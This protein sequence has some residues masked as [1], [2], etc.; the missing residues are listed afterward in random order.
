[1]RG[2]FSRLTF[3]PD[4][5][6]TAVLFQQGRVQLDADA[7]EEAAIQLA[8][9]RTMAADVIGQHGGPAD[10]FEVT[11]VPRTE[12]GDPATLRIQRGRYYVDGVLADST[13]PA[14]ERPVTGE[15]PPPAGDLTYWDQ[16]FAYLDPELESDALPGTFPFLVYLRVHE[17]L[18]TAV[19]DPGIRESALGPALPDTAVRTRVVWQ[20]RAVDLGR[21]EDPSSAFQAWVERSR[22]HAFLAARTERPARVEDDPCIVAPDAA[23]R[24]EENQLYRVEIHQGGDAGTATFKWSR[25]NGSVTFPIE[26]I[27][28][29][30]VTLG[31][32]GRD[33]RLGLHVGDWTEVSDDASA[34]RGETGPLLR[35]EEIDVVGR[36]VRLSDEPAAGVGRIAS[37]HPL[38]RRWDQRRQTKRGAPELRDGAVRVVEGA[39]LDLEDGVQVWFDGKGTYR[40]GDYWLIPA[41]TLE[42]DVEWPR[43]AAGEPLLEP[44]AGVDV[45]YAPL[46]WVTGA[47]SEDTQ[48]LRH[49]FRPLTG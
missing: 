4:R 17:Q 8:L 7:N 32:L 46:A 49:Q 20:V 34:A 45:H 27:G 5:H 33:D 23:F 13:A 10:G 30:W 35:V 28:G 21:T 36:R 38:L 14:P 18:V 19:E 6:F 15:A 37:R 48:S 11:F 42:A 43:S 16:P 12:S 25:D 24:G 9:A 44:P 1:M 29:A 39:W 2:D 3:R 31:S 47:G 40:G 41:R 22:A 26:A